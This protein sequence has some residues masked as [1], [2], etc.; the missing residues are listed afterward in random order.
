[1]KIFKSGIGLLVLLLLSGCVVT[2]ETNSKNESVELISNRINILGSEFTLYPEDNI[3]LREGRFVSG[4]YFFNG[5]SGEDTFSFAN[6]TA[7]KARFIYQKAEKGRKFELKDIEGYEFTVM[8]F[9][10]DENYI[11]LKSEKIKNP[12]IS[13]N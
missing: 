7:N 5:F 10:R 8:D 1:M 4:R 12:K 11:K 13:K 2:S 3:V 6:D 9:N